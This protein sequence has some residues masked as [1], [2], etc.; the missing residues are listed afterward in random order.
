MLYF[1]YNLYLSEEGI[2]SLLRNHE[3]DSKIIKGY[4]SSSAK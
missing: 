1:T 2:V 4:F 3:Q